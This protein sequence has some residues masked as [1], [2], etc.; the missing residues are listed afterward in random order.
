M[1]RINN[2]YHLHKFGGEIWYVSKSGNDSNNGKT[3]D[4]AKLTIKAA[5]TASSAGDAINIKAGTYDEVDLVIANNG[6]ELWGEIGALVNN[7][8]SGGG[9]CIQIT[10]NSCKV[11][12]IKVSQAGQIGF[13]I[14]GA[15]CFLD[16]CIAEDC[17]IAFDVDGAGN[18]LQFC[19]DV[20]ATTTGY[21]IATAENLL[22]HCSTIASG[23]ASRGFYLSN[24]AA[25][26]N[27]IYQCLSTGNATAGYEVVAGASYNVF[28]F[29]TSGGGESGTRI[30]LG[31]KTQ[32]A[33][34]EFTL[35][36][37]HH[38]NV[39]PKADGIGGTQAPI[40]VTDLAGSESGTR[41]DQWY[42]G[43][44]KVLIAPAVNTGIWSLMGYNIFAST[45][46]K[47][48]QAS[49]Y[50]I[51][52]SLQSAKNGGNA[53]DE[54][55]TVLTVTDGTK[56]AV[57]DLVW[58]YS[59]YKTDG[60]IVKITG[61]STHEIT[62]ARETVASAETGLRWNHTTNDA[63]TEIMYVVYRPTFTGMHTNDFNHSAGS[64]K[65]FFTSRFHAHREFKA[66]DGILVR[67]LCLDS[68][69]CTFDMTVI[70]ED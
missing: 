54:G 22:F 66:N 3:P 19:Q 50:R 47:E 41:D 44:P 38:E 18:I 70:I 21:D 7:T 57:N 46:N 28:A 4:K 33:G 64:S 40:T 51:N 35:P 42:W 20:N 13:D 58:I 24:A 37:E 14:D 48:M 15:G 31:T 56:F 29:C 2:T 6:T 27:L 34:C 12:G 36:R 65:D 45:A 69:T 68:A 49:I 10:G 9:T 61:I 63:G 26:E 32:W 30:D 43:E 60:E 53:W 17:T 23:G 67:M 16:H 39:Y 1:S 8:D 55:A 5:V 62:I 11:L 52:H 25:D 59:D